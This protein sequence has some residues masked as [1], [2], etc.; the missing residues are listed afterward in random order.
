MKRLLFPLLVVAALLSFGSSA[1]AGDGSGVG[2]AYTISNAAAGNQLVVYSRAA[3]GSLARAGS[4]SAGGLGT[5]AG[6]ASQGA[7]TVTD[8]GRTVLAVNP[9]SNSVAAFAVEADVPRLLSTAPRAAFVP[10]ASPC[11]RASSTC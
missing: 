6:L 3:N 2:A 5:G 9:G 8:D 1:V 11:T 4:V 10:S 7:V